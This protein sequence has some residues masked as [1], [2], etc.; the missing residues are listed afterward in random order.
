[1]ELTEDNKHIDHLI[2]RYL[3]GEATHEEKLQLEKWMNESEENKKFFNDNRFVHDKAVSSHKLIRVDVDK[4]WNKM[5]G[6]MKLLHNK[7]AVKS[8]KKSLYLFPVWL[9]VAA[10][11]LLLTGM[12][13]WMYKIFFKTKAEEV[14]AISSTDSVVHNK[15]PDNSKIVLNK[16][17]KITC[18]AGF[19]KKNR[20][21]VL[22]GEAYFNIKHSADTPFVVKTENAIIKDIGTTFNV[23]SYDNSNNIEVYVESGE[24]QFYT[25][26][27]SGIVIRKGETGIYDKSAKT[28]HKTGISET[29]VISYKT[30]V[31]V[32]RNTNLV[33]AVNQLNSVYPESIRINDTMLMKCPITVTFDNEDLATIANVI[34]ETLGLKVIKSPDGYILEGKSCINYR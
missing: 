30:R 11:V 34:A 23:K 8:I 28:F 7:P 17:S 26:S 18:S 24:V 9:R 13:F 20:E 16:K 19:G 12:S 21:V 22:K 4:A 32:F 6:Q 31:F 15:L 5:Q 10:S 27:N 3:A 33:E 25:L 2:T 29:N 14:F 1:L